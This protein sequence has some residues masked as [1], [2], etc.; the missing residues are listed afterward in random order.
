MLGHLIKGFLSIV[1]VG[2]VIIYV[3]ALLLF[4]EIAGHNIVNLLL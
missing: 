2:A 3:S 1:D 4:V